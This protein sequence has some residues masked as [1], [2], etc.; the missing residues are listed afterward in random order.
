[1]SNDFEGQSNNI[2]LVKFN[3]LPSIQIK[4]NDAFDIVL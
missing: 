1:M 4:F 2:E 3:F